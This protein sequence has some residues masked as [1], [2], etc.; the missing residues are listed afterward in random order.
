[1]FDENG[2]QNTQDATD[3]IAVPIDNGGEFLGMI[4]KE[5]GCLSIV[6]SKTVSTVSARR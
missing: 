5:E 6:R 1:M 2:L 3:F 4:A